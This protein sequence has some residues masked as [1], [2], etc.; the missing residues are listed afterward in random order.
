MISAFPVKRDSFLNLV[1]GKLNVGIIAVRSLL[2]EII[3]SHNL[4]QQYSRFQ[5][6]IQKSTDNLSIAFFRANP[7]AFPKE[8]DEKS[9]SSLDPIIPP[10]F[11]TVHEYLR[12]GGEIPTPITKAWLSMD[13]GDLLKTSYEYESEFPMED[14][15]FLRRL[16]ALPMNIQG[17]MF[18]ADINILHGIAIRLARLHRVNLQE[19]RELQHA[20]DE[21]LAAICAGEY[22]FAEKFALLAD[23]LDSGNV[24]MR[25]EE[26]ADVGRFIVQSA[27]EYLKNYQSLLG[28]PYKS[29]SPALKKLEGSIS[30]IPVEQ[31]AETPVAQRN[32]AVTMDYESTKRD[33]AGSITKI[34]QFAGMSQDQIKQVNHEMDSLRKLENPFDS[35]TDLRKIRRQI[36]K[37]YWDTY[38]NAY[39]K[40][41]ESRGNVPLPVR[42]MLYYGFFDEQFLKP[43]QLVE[44]H[45]LADSSVSNPAYSIL[46][47]VD[48]LTKVG[49][50][51]EFPS[52]DEMGLTFFEKLKADHK[53]L[54]W[55][56]ESDVPEEFDNFKTRVN[57]E[58]HHFLDTT[59][60]LTSG[61]P[62]TAFPILTHHQ[63]I[64]PFDK[65]YA[66]YER[67]S[68]AV[69]QIL[70]VDFTA[71]HREVLVNDEAAGIIKEFVQQKVIPN[72]IIVP[73]IGTKVFMWQEL[74][75]RSKSSLGRIA[76]PA[77]ATADLYTMVLEAV[78]AFRWEL[79]KTIQ[80][81]DWNNVSVPSVTADY[82]DYVQFYKKNRDLSPEIKEKLAS[83]F[84]RFRT[85]RDRFVNDYINWIKSESEGVLKLNKVARSIF[86][87][88]IPFAKAKRDNLSSQ[89]AYADLHE[90]FTNIR[91]KKLKELEV[92]YRKYGDNIPPILKNNIDFYRV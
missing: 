63:V 10:A 70:A 80:G 4:I 35:A 14:F 2:Q 55:R 42:L 1:M 90:R 75:G 30:A 52:V 89:P 86:Y 56:R 54:G 47:A 18:K 85:D 22:C 68:K 6:S 21:N 84:K 5:S 20:L 74:S 64:L 17:A 27:K 8:M 73:S 32:T 53:D 39:M 24:N 45:A 46:P 48:W 79:T 82:T 44:L 31:K 51:D 49:K 29:I 76:I 41:N 36:T 3:S 50:K 43:E 88:H 13:H 61:S 81:P 62:A 58:I 77:F 40:F 12:N 33:L 65:C 72:F 19:L 26:F 25:K 57:F 34:M 28:V 15:Q 37:T 92:R 83:E 7:S 87:R 66:T 59:V 23:V 38:E 60:R 67:I 9:E 78:G 91:R 16:L 71:F 11:R 69:D